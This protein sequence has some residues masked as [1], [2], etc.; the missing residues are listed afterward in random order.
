MNKSTITATFQGTDGSMGLRRKT[1]YLIELSQN[2]E[3]G[4]ITLEHKV[5]D[6]MKDKYFG[7]M[8]RKKVIRCEYGSLHAFLDNWK[9]VT[10]WD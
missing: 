5:E 1:S 2:K 9:G 8:S 6:H 7:D 10:K 4:V 3:T